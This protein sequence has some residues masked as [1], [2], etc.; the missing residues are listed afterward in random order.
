MNNLFFNFNFRAIN[1]CLSPSSLP[2]EIVLGGLDDRAEAEESLTE[3][4]TPMELNESE[5]E[6]RHFLGG[7]H[8]TDKRQKTKDSI[9][10]VYF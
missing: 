5:V 8:K 4:S 1:A 9:S 7:K 6:K 10:E 2:E 3:P